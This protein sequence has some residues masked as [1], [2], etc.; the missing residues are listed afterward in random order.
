MCKGAVGCVLKVRWECVK[1]KV[2]GFVKGQVAVCVKGE[3][4]GCVKGQWQ[5]V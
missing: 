1:S 2:T 4:T 5:C 3:L